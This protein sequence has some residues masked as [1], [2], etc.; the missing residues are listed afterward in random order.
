MLH[1]PWEAESEVDSLIGEVLGNGLQLTPKNKGKQTGPAEG[2]LE[3]WCNLRQSWETATS[4]PITLAQ[5]QPII[6]YRW[7]ARVGSWPWARLALHSWDCAEVINPAV[8]KEMLIGA[9]AFTAVVPQV[10]P[11]NQQITATW[12]GNTW[13]PRIPGT[14]LTLKFRGWGVAVWVFTSPQK[15]LETGYRVWGWLLYT[16]VTETFCCSALLR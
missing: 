11:L 15:N 16:Q 7:P 10:W 13:E 5:H 14:H 3:L 2:E 8:L 4:R 9:V 1:I 6:R 12:P